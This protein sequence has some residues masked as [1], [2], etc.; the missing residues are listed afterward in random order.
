MELPAFA[1]WRFVGAV[2]G[3]EVVYAR[4]GRLRGHTSAVEAGR[5]YAVTYEIAVDASWRTRSVEVTSETP[6]G[7]RS[8]HLLSDGAGT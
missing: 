4:P 1:A 3:F 8:T 2:D 6:A 7:V 5:P